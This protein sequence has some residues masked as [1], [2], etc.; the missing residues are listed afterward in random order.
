MHPLQEDMDAIMNATNMCT[1]Y[2]SFKFKINTYMIYL[3][4][5]ILKI[6]MYSLYKIFRHCF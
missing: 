4:D 2:K 1:S 3:G 5:H 6:N